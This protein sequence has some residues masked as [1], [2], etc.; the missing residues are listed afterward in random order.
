MLKK[1]TEL[2]KSGKKIRGNGGNKF[3]GGK[4]RNGKGKICPVPALARCAR[5][6][7]PRFLLSEPEFQAGRC[8]IR[9]ISRKLIDR[10]RRQELA[11]NRF[12]G[13]A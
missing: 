2:K 12:G 1:N 4:N 8:L 9:Q 10:H 11:K 6:G 5:D 7:V 3:Q 13:G